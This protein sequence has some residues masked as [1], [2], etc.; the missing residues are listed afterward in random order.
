MKNLL[1]LLAALTVA[2]SGCTRINFPYRIDVEQGN[3]LTQ[4]AVD[5]LRP[6]M[7]RQQ[8]AFA[9]G[10]PLI[11]YDFHPERWDYY[12]SFQSGKGGALVKRRVALFFHGDSLV[13]IEGDMRPGGGD[14]AVADARKVDVD[15]KDVKK[16]PTTQRQEYVRE[17]IEDVGG[18]L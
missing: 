1:V 6:G 12:Y 15:Q 18:R 10:S 4:E 14:E 17:R 8:V 9:L 16:P 2:V 11:T 3:V 7:D 5:A 13:R